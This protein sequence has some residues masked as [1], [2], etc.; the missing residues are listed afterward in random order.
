MYHG[1]SLAG[2]GRVGQQIA[3]PWPLWVGVRAGRDS[4]VHEGGWLG[5]RR[6]LGV[7]LSGMEDVGGDAWLAAVVGA[8]VAAIRLIL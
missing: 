5:G 4:K 8:G 7:P 2:S 3:Y 1:D 6:I